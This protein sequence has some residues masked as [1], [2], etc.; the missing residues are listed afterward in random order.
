MVC[1]A[2]LGGSSATSCTCRRKDKDP[3]PSADLPMPVGSYSGL[4][5]SLRESGL[6][7]EGACEQPPWSLEDQQRHRETRVSI[8]A[9]HPGSGV[10]ALPLDELS[11]KDARAFVSEVRSRVFEKVIT[12]GT[13]GLSPAER[14]V[15]PASK[16]A[17][18]RRTRNEQ[19]SRI[20]NE[21]QA[22][23]SHDDAFY[24]MKD[25]DAQVAQ[26]LRSHLGELALPPR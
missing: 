21:F 23:R 17:E 9:N 2:I 3:G 8:A 12:R 6:S 13:M 15:F 25:E 11:K 10:A 18:D 19:M 4:V 14:A 22:W 20:P 24:A 1:V 5:G 7:P 16:P 26:Y